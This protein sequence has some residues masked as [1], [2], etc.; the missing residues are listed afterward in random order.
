MKCS[1]W[2]WFGI[3]WTIVNLIIFAIC[4]GLAFTIYKT[5]TVYYEADT[6]FENCV[7]YQQIVYNP[8]GS[9]Y[10]NPDPSIYT[11]PAPNAYPLYECD[12][13]N[14]NKKA[15]LIIAYEE[16]SQFF[17]HLPLV[18]PG[19]RFYSDYL[20]Y[21]TII[22]LGIVYNPP[23]ARTQHPTAWTVLLVIG[24]VCVCIGVGW[25]LFMPLV[26]TWHDEE[27]GGQRHRLQQ[28]GPNN[29]L[30]RDIENNDNNVANQA[31]G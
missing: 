5:E 18:Y 15:L 10:S 23:L 3:P 1:W 7:S 16:T 9:A 20:F 31:G 19:V 13:V 2:Y 21:P 6:V 17:A 12:V 29:N 24:I 25:M 27:Q 14:Q 28:I 8:S 4:F 30:G 22:P 26:F 11:F